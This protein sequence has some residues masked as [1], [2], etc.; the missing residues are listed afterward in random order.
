MLK[1]HHRARYMI[2]SQV[3]MKH[4]VFPGYV[5]PNEIQFGN[6]LR[7]A[8]PSSIHTILTVHSKIYFTTATL[9]LSL[10]QHSDVLTTWFSGHIL[11]AITMIMVIISRCVRSIVEEWRF[12]VKESEQI[13]VTVK[14][15][16]IIIENSSLNAVILSG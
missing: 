16:Y 3:L 4:R 8:K 5:Y 10:L 11:R 13:Y 6:C 15:I 12:C 2:K 14:A 1:P 7:L 9:W